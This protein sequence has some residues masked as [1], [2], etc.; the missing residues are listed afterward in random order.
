MSVCEDWTV[1]EYRGADADDAED[2][3]TDDDAQA[4]RALAVILAVFGD[5]TPLLGVR[6]DDALDHLPPR[7]VRTMEDVHLLDY[8]EYQGEGSAED[9]ED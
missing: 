2:V 6:Y 9:S 7:K 8:D 3:L 1:D 5:E 4:E